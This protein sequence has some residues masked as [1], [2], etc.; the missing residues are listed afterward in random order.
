MAFIAFT[1]H[2]PAMYASAAPISALLQQTKGERPLIQPIKLKPKKQI[3]A[4]LTAIERTCNSIIPVPYVTAD[5][6]A[7]RATSYVIILPPLA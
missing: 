1:A 6:Y 2:A 5:L 4:I 3:T 7:R